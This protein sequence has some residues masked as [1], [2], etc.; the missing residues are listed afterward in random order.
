MSDLRILATRLKNC[1]RPALPKVDKRGAASHSRPTM[2][3]I[4]I[5][6]SLR[7]AE[8]DLRA[9][10]L[11]SARAELERA[12]QS[13]PNVE[14]WH[15]TALVEKSAGNAAAASSAFEA[16]LQISPDDPTILMNFAN[17]KQALGEYDTALGLYDRALEF[18]PNSGDLRFNRVLVLTTLGRVGEALSQIDALIAALPSEARL[19]STRGIIL[20]ALGRLPEAGDAFDRALALDPRR[21][22]ALHG[23]AQIAKDRDEE[24]ASEHYRRAL[25]E[26]PGQ[27]DLLLGLAEA[28]E[29][30]GEAGA[31]VQTLEDAVRTNPAWVDG[32]AALARMRWE[33]SK[34]EGFLFD[35]EAALK[36]QPG[37]ADLW[38]VL[39]TTLAGADLPA[40]AAQAASEGV[41]ATS[42]DARLKLLEAFLVSEAG[43]T[44]HADKLFAALPVGMPNRAF[45]EGRHALRAHRFNEASRLLDVARE[46]APWDIAVWAMIG[47][48]WRLTGDPRSEWLNLQPGLIRTLE[49]DLQ[50]D[51]IGTIAEGLRTLHRTRMRP[52]HQSL[53]GGTQSR[54]RLFERPEAEIALLGERIQSAVQ[55]YWD[56]LPAM[57]AAHPL[58]R[59]RGAKPVIEGSWSVRL[60][61]GGFH[62][63]HFHPEGIVSS[64]AYIVVPDSVSKGEG[65]LEIGAAPNDLKLPL[66]PIATVEP[67][68]GRLALFPSF[69]FHSTRPFSEGERMTVAFDVVTAA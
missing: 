34:D 66:E 64:A 43:E 58:L 36:S 49:L 12:R 2:T 55:G 59:H 69:M 14:A 23:R 22:I 65:W 26:Y 1:R 67:A 51:E 16:A 56:A 40:A 4:D 63:A 35:L 18:A 27:G 47:L 41:R 44:E 39:A 48:A 3:I 20:R 38:S 61:G 25:A 6:P 7:R 11:D 37:N 31:A 15:L 33:A 52:L 32:Q 19:H 10:R 17:L 13:G 21:L 68:P 57:D 24:G 29:A 46:E 45:S 62:I 28:L 42:G 5:D 50:A 8:A 54:G 30:E 60:T 9:G 53:R